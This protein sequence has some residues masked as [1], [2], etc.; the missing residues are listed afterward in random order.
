MKP[1]SIEISDNC[2]GLAEVDGFSL[3]GVAC[4]IRNKNDMSRLDLALIKL[5]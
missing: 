4:N 2:S 1:Y 3:A 5:E